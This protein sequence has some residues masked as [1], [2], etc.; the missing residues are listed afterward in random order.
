[1]NLKKNTH[2]ASPPSQLDRWRRLGLWLVGATMAYNILEGGIAL[3]AGLQA[4][5]IA[6]L[7][8]L[9][10]GI[11]NWPNGWRERMTHTRVVLLPKS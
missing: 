6:L 10:L 9:W 2:T 7:G 4:G 8:L 3:W 11:D 1:M 5:S